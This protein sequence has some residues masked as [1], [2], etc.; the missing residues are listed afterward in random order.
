MDRFVICVVV[1]DLIWIAIPS[2]VVSLLP[3]PRPVK[4]WSSNAREGKEG[5]DEDKLKSTADDE[6]SRSPPC[7]RNGVKGRLETHD[8]YPNGLQGLSSIQE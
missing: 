5:N 4:I 1:D 2:M 8:E 7:V 3:E 6:A